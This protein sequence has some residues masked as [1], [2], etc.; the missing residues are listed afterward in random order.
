MKNQYKVVLFSIPHH[1]SIYHYSC[2]ELPLLGETIELETG[3][4]LFSITETILLPATK[5]NYTAT[6]I[7]CGAVTGKHLSPEDFKNLKYRIHRTSNIDIESKSFGNVVF[8]K[9]LD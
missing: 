4:I 2:A 9:T 5:D 3:R 8:P 7:L 6:Y 1:D